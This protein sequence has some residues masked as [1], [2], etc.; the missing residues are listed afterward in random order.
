MPLRCRCPHPAAHTKGEQHAAGQDC[1]KREAILPGTRDRGDS[2]SRGAAIMDGW[3]WD[4][5][6]LFRVLIGIWTWHLAIPNEE[7]TAMTGCR[8]P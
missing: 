2:L 7:R 3:V 4:S 1:G 6:M 5:S 8:V